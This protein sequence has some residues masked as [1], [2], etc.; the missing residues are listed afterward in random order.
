M[1]AECRGLVQYFYLKAPI[2][3]EEGDLWEPIMFGNIICD[4][5]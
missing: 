2:V 1:L 4:M 5:L 3:P